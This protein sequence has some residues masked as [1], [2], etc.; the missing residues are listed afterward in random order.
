MNTHKT[1]RRTYIIYNSEKDYRFLRKRAHSNSFVVF[2]IIFVVLMTNRISSEY[3][4]RMK[5]LIFADFMYYHIV[6]VE[7]TQ[8]QYIDYRIH[9]I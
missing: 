1:R 5:V 4:P 7:N 8:A 2:I 6:I 9:P 3:V